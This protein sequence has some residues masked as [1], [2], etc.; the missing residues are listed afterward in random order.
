MSDGRRAIFDAIKSA[1]G[2]ATADKARR[3]AVAERLRSPPRHPV[4]A[5]ARKAP[6]DLRAQFCAYLEGQAATVVPVATLA[7]VPAAVSDYLR[8]KNLPQCVRVGSDARLAALPW[9]AQPG[10]ERRPGPAKSNDE[11]GLSHA[12][13]GVSETGTLVLVSG[14]ENPVTINFLP[15]THIVVLSATDIVGAYED[16]WDKIRATYGKR[17]MPRTVNFISG[18]SR[19]ADIASQ[20]VMGAHGP[21]RLCVIVVGP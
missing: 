4:P 8:Q 10:L 7:D 11:T 16:A 13:A 17:V 15:E 19:T 1:L 21:R 5:R 14:P 20:L 2:E 6:G 9:P 12:C 3:L 18:P